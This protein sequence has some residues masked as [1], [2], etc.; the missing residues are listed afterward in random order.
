MNNYLIKLNAKNII[1]INTTLCIVIILICYGFAQYYN[2]VD[3]WIP[4]ISDC[5]VYPPENYIS[6]F[7]VISFINC[8]T[9]LSNVLI[10]KFI[11]V[12]K[13]YENLL[14]FIG[15]FSSMCFGLVGSI[16]ENENLKMH[17]VFAI[18]GFISYG[19]FMIIINLYS[20]YKNWLVFC[21]YSMNIFSKYT[22]IYFYTSQ[23]SIVE[24]ISSIL[25]AINMFTYGSY[26]SEE[27]IYILM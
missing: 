24:W 15:I 25:F 2:H 14:M 18:S 11:K 10:S 19:L 13:K 9:G 20:N 5:F 27:Y 12:E 21:V 8:G 4:M 16:S 23:K 22:P 17:N 1:Y 6:R 26:M 3:S 7:G